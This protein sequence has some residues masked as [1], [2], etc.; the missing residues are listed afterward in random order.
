MRKNETQQTIHIENLR[1]TKAVLDRL[2]MTF[3]LSHGS[4]LGIYRECGIIYHTT[5]IDV[6]VPNYEVLDLELIMREMERESFTLDS[7][8]G[9]V[10]L[11]LEFSYMREGQK[12]DIFIFYKENVTLENEKKKFEHVWK[13]TVE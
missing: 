8:Y 5:D 7:I 13:V 6:G 11:G 3:F 12:I 10:D 2:N 1:R 4:I 9:T